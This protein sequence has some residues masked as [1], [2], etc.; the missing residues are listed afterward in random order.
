MFPWIILLFIIGV[1]LLAVEFFLPGFGIFGIL[2]IVSFCVAVL[3]TAIEYGVFHMCIAIGIIIFIV[4]ILLYI[5]KK[6]KMYNKVILTETI[7]GKD[8]DEDSLKPFMNKE[9]IAITPLKP[10]GK[11]DFDG[12]IIEVFANAGY[13][14]KGAKVL[15]IN[16]S[17]K[18]V[19]VKEIKE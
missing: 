3:M 14:S 13:I 5:A 12:E 2:G 4:C 10:Y 16:I 6:N 1:L 8:F 11:V 19:V 15:V 18:N 9:G 17:G 7:D